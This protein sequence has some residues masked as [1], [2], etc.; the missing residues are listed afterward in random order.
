MKLMDRLNEPMGEE[1]TVVNDAGIRK[2]TSVK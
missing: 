2:K 1:D